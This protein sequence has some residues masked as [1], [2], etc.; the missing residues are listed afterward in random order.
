M[1]SL[2]CQLDARQDLLPE[3]RHDTGEL[4]I[5]TAVARTFC[6]KVTAQ[7]SVLRVQY[8]YRR[9]ASWPM[10]LVSPAPMKFKR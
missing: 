3:H 9:M 10:E 7:P 2:A 4:R 1:P 6:S 8:A 5:D